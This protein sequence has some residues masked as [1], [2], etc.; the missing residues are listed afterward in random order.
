MI[1]SIS[2]IGIPVK[3]I[4]RASRFYQGT[5]ELP[6]LFQTETMAFFQLAGQTLMLTLPEKDEFD[7]PSSVLY[8]QVADI[9]QGYQY[10]L[11]KGVSFKGKPHFVAKVGEAETWMAFFEDTEGNTHALKAEVPAT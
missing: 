8:F 10:Y 2:Q 6:L 9:Q 1:Q 11:K 4:Q 5:L 3:D 7:H